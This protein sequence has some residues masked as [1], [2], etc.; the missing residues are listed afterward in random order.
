MILNLVISI[1]FSAGKIPTVKYVD[2]DDIATNQVRLIPKDKRENIS[3][4]DD[5]NIDAEDIQTI[6]QT[7]IYATNPKPSR[8]VSQ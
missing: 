2:S 5:I 3:T 7:N 4:V 8:L 1:Y 6:K